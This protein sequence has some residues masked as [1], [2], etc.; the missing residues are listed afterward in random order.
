MEQMRSVSLMP[1]GPGHARL[2][3]CMHTCSLSVYCS[4]QFGE[5]MASG[6]EGEVWSGTVKSIPKAIKK[7]RCAATLLLVTS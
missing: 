5:K 2:P 3:Y 7:I 1:T 6:V 4:L